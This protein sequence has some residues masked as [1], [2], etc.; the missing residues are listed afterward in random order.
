LETV[1]LDDV[2]EKMKSRFKEKTGEIVDAY[3]RVFPGLKPVEI[4][5]L[6]ASNRQPPVAAADAK[7][8]QKAP[9]FVAWFGSQPELFDG[10]MRAFHCLDIS[11]WFS[12]TDRIYTHTGGGAKARK[13]ATSMT[14]ALL[15]FMRTGNPNGSSLPE[16]PR[17]TSEN[18]ETMI[19][20]IASAV[21]NDPDREAR[22]ALP[23]S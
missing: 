2:K 18:E 15:Q 21:K 22:K 6:V 9:V 1:S 12:N 19:L 11:F 10:R 16:W 5:S 13:L 4:W 8:K 20:N 23:V 14:Q 7:S 17:Y 3:N